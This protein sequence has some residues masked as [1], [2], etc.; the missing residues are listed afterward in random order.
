MGEI[1]SRQKM[2]AHA[3]LPT[4]PS[5]LDVQTSLLGGVAGRRELLATER[6]QSWLQTYVRAGL[7]SHRASSTMCDQQ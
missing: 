3:V 6:L 1:P 5:G 4:K 7:G 2:H